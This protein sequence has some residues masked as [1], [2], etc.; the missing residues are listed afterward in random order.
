MY[1]KLTTNMHISVGTMQQS[2][3]LLVITIE[4][5]AYHEGASF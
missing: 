1:Q 2:V 3:A 4:V 5:T